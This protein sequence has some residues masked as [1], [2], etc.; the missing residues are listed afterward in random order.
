MAAQNHA[1]RRCDLTRR[2]AAGGYLIKQRLEEM[3][4]AAIDEG[5]RERGLAKPLGRVK[6]GE[7]A[8]DND[9]PMRARER[10]VRTWLDLVFHPSI[11]TISGAGP[12]PA[13]PFIGC[14][15]GAPGSRPSATVEPP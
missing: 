15:R 14:L 11:L 8:A 10:P 1:Q 7:T 4:I 6:A 13:N 12:R 9:H 3:K 2:K 5:E